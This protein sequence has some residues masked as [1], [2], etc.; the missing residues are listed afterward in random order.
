M[1]TDEQYLCFSK[2]GGAG[3]IKCR[4]CGYEE[5]NNKFHAWYDVM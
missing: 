3:V 4:D 2:M 5:K 1:K